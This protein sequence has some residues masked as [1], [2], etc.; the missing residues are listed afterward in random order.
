MFV[1]SFLHSPRLQPHHT[2]LANSLPGS[3]YKLLHTNLTVTRGFRFSVNSV[4]SSFRAWTSFKSLL[5][6]ENS[7]EAAVSEKDRKRKREKERGGREAGRSQTDRKYLGTVSSPCEL[8]SEL[9]RSVTTTLRPASHAEV[10][11]EN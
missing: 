3:I 11:L 7:I 4:C 8:L 6:V 5:L 2:E 1:F 9:Q 10:A